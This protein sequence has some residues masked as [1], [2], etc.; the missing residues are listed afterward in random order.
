MMAKKPFCYVAYDKRDFG[1]VC[2]PEPEEMLSD[3]L[4]ERAQAGDTIQPLYSREE[5]EAVL[6]KF[7]MR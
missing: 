4:L 5:Y 3:F 7:G 1:G 6:T 2:A